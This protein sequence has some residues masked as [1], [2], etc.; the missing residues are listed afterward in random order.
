MSRENLFK[1]EIFIPAEIAQTPRVLSNEF[2]IP[3]A[4][5]NSL[6][7][8]NEVMKVCLYEKMS[9]IVHD[10]LM[11]DVEKRLQRQFSPQ[12]FPDLFPMPKYYHNIDGN[13]D[14]IITDSI[15]I[16]E[17][18]PTFEVDLRPYFSVQ[19]MIFIFKRVDAQFDNMNELHLVV[20]TIA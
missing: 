2:Y 14:G 9:D 19:K 13:N 5:S 1:T 6:S 4:G 15:F 20:N 7:R 11:S 18:I 17:S 16:W 8:Q 12:S 10:N 3:F